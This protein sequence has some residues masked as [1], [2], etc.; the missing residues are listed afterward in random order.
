[1]K[2]K[3]KLRRLENAHRALAARNEAMFQVSKIVFP[4][5]GMICPDISKRLTTSIYD[6]TNAHMERLEFDDEYQHQV[7]KG[8]DELCELIMTAATRC[9]GQQVQQ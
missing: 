5:I 9:A 8:V 3:K 7:R 6:A 4:L 1:M 2:T